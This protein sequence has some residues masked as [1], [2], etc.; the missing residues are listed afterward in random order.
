[1]KILGYNEVSLVPANKIDNMAACSTSHYTDN[2]L[3][4]CDCQYLSLSFM[5][6]RA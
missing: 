6:P 1:M 3:S 2:L 4:A 5:Q